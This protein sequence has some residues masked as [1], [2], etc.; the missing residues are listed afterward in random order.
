M[1]E[2]KETLK[3]I[4]NLEEMF[5]NEGQDIEVIFGLEEIKRQINKI[6]EEEK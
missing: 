6:L 4:D 1:E 3:T 2:L 5:E